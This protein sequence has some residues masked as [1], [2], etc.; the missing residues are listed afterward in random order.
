M[1]LDTFVGRSLEVKIHRITLIPASAVQ[2]RSGRGRKGP[3]E[4]HHER[5]FRQS[6][7]RRCRSTVLLG[8]GFSAE[9][10]AQKKTVVV[11]ACSRGPTARQRPRIV[12]QKSLASGGIE[13][14]PDKKLAMVEADLGLIK[15][16]DSYTAVARELKV[17]AF[18][19]GIVHRG[20][21]PKAR[22][23]VRN[24]DGKIIG[25]QGWQATSLP[26]LMAAVN[27]TAGPEA[28][29][30]SGA[31]GGGAAAG[32]RPW[33]RPSRPRTC[34]PAPS[35][36]PGPAA[37][38]TR[39]RPRT[40][41]RRKSRAEEERGRGRRGGRGRRRRR[42]GRGRG[43]RGAQ[44]KTKAAAAAGT[45]LN[46]AFVLRMFSRNFSYNQSM[47]GRPAGLP[48]ARAAVQQPAAGA[49]ARAWRSSTSRCRTLAV[50]LA[51]TRHR[52]LEGQRRQRLQDH[53]STPGRSGAKGRIRRSVAARS[54]RR[55]A[56]AA[57]CSR[58]TNFATG[59]QPHPGGA[60]STTGTSA[61][62]PAC[63]C[64]SAAAARSRP[65]ATTCTSSSAG[66]ILDAT[67]TSRATPLGG[68][69]FAGVMHARSVHQGPRLRAGRRLPPG[70]LRF[71]PEAR[72]PTGASPAAPSTSTS[73]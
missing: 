22:V 54:S 30:L 71:T 55:S 19:G 6:F 57:T 42:R 36:E 45:G 2:N 51:T 68:E 44:R 70:R 65:A 58:S 52:R 11:R 46:L 64:R 47:R 62:A 61:S 14:V 43:G 50:Q 27:A 5:P 3:Q 18:V 73:A 56:T 28:G 31:G 39:R 67:S 59:C 1:F 8:S 34:W 20:R 26:K 38:R 25:A 16:S 12:V 32:G 49:R 66:D 40:R 48:G 7:L 15:V 13:V 60:A 72:P 29:G 69:L 63:A 21:R 23:V 4:Q 24:A 17:N 53:A 41:G 9:A 37:P 35:E 10:F 33:P